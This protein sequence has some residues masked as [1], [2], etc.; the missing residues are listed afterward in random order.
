[1]LASAFFCQDPGPIRH[2]RL[3]AHVLTVTAVQIGHPIAKFIHV[4]SN[5]GLLHSTNLPH[6]LMIDSLGVCY[7]PASERM[8]TQTKEHA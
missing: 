6:I 2:R 3:M 4:I 1:M 5:N 8:L 7:T